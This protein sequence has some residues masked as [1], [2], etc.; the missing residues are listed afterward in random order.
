[1]RD[2]LFEQVMLIGEGKPYLSVIAVLERGSL[3]KAGA[4]HGLDAGAGS[5][6]ESRP[7]IVLER[8]AHSSGSFRATRRCGG[9]RSRSS[10]GPSKTACL[11]RP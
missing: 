7:S 10:R 8:I 11:R 5:A 6:I 4:E 3:E 1:M 9:R 2:A